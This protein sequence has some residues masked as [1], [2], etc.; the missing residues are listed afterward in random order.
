MEIDSVSSDGET[1]GSQD[2]DT[3]SD[4]YMSDDSVPVLVAPISQVFVNQLNKLRDYLANLQHNMDDRWEVIRGQRNND[5]TYRHPIYGSHKSKPRVAVRLG[6]P[7][8]PRATRVRHSQTAPSPTDIPMPTQIHAPMIPAPIQSAVA[9]VQN[10]SQ[11]IERLREEKEELVQKY[12]E[13]RLI[14]EKAVASEAET[15]SKMEK[16]ESIY[17]S[18]HDHELSLRRVIEIQSIL[19][20]RILQ[21]SKIIRDKIQLRQQDECPVCSVCLQNEPTHCLSKCGHAFCMNCITD[22]KNH[23]NT[24][25]PKCQGRANWEKIVRFYL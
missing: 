1:L 16:C 22:L 6:L 3:D 4:D 12:D 21:I 23:Q 11:D 20:S 2:T 5:W 14:A 15:L 17:C 24:K 7:V 8:P 13:A 18:D 9:F 25:C 19:N 10:I